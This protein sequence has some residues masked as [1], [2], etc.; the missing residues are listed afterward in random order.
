M[1]VQ[2]V[3]LHAVEHALVAA[4]FR[5]E[6]GV[7]AFPIDHFFVLGRAVQVVDRVA[8]G[9][10]AIIDDGS[11]FFIA[12]FFGCAGV[13]L[14]FLGRACGGGSARVRRRGDEVFVFQHFF[15]REIR[16]GGKRGDEREG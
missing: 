4:F 16:V 3:A 10:V 8:V 12:R 2:A 7:V 9:C 11:V 1:V 5:A 6:P 15:R 14:G 13:V